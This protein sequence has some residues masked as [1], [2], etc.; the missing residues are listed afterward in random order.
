MP[1]EKEC[2]AS[3]YA[4]ADEKIREEIIRQAERL[5]QDL[6]SAA[7]TIDQRGAVMVA[8]FTPIATA[9]FAFLIGHAGSNLRVFIIISGIAFA[10]A[11]LFSLISIWPTKKWEPI[12]YYPADWAEDI[13]NKSITLPQAQGEMLVYYDEG[14]RANNSL[15]GRRNKW[16]FCALLLVLS[17]PV[18]GLAVLGLRC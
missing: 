13:C 6:N 4:G 8:V 9:A 2:T 15:N 10:L 14:L 12:A 18:I 7:Q 17:V 3:D 5:A 11:A 1:S 16:Q